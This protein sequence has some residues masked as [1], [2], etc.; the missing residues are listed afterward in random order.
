MREPKRLL[1]GSATDFERQLLQ[2]V[3]GERPSPLLKA[4]MQQGLGLAGA[5]TWAGGAKAAFGVVA[6]KVALV[7]AVGGAIA[8][9]GAAAIIGLEPGTRAEASPVGIAA[10]PAR[11]DGDVLPEADAPEAA[12]REVTAREVTAPESVDP[13]RL[14]SRGGVA[15]VAARAIDE[16][17]SRVAEGQLREEIAALDAARAALQA[18]SVA[19]ALAALDDYAQRFSGGILKREAEMLRRQALAS[20][21][22]AGQRRR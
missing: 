11:A 22:A 13:R 1:S 6:K 19:G 7:A 17:P 3:V 5:V 18:G 15:P 12:T 20:R 10:A 16:A 21:P 14:G 4:R 8:A 9:A 2:A